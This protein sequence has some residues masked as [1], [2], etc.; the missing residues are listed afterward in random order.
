MYNGHCQYESICKF[1]N[2]KIMY[3]NYVLA[4]DRRVLL[5]YRFVQHCHDSCCLL[6]LCQLY[7]TP[8]A[9]HIISSIVPLCCTIITGVVWDSTSLLFHLRWLSYR[10]KQVAINV[11]ASIGCCL[12]H[13]LSDGHYEWWTGGNVHIGCQ[14][15]RWWF[16]WIDVLPPA[17]IIVS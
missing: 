10:D 5:V 2:C 7:N 16:I 3:S 9:Q 12:E 4:F 15:V 11:I 8:A 17:G 13:Q 6:V 1:T 14:S